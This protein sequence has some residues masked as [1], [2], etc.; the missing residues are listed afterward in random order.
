MFPRQPFSETHIRREGHSV[1]TC[2]FSPPSHNMK[3]NTPTIFVIYLS[4]GFPRE[5]FSSVCSPR[6]SFMSL[7]LPLCPGH[8]AAPPLPNQN[9]SLRTEYIIQS[10]LFVACFSPPKFPFRLLHLPSVLQLPSSFISP[11]FS[12]YLPS[13]FEI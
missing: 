9:S 10:Y 8:P 13:A 1:A 5:I 4:R 11:L 6:S 3:G 12:P 7:P 2:K